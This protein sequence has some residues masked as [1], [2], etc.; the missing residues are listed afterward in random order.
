MRWRERG[1]QWRS[2][3][4]CPAR[5]QMGRETVINLKH[6]LIDRGCRA[7]RSDCL[8]EVTVAPERRREQ[9]IGRR[10]N[11]SVCTS[12]RCHTSRAHFGRACII[13]LV[14]RAGGAIVR[15]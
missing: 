14:Q 1:D 2:A 10:T 6:A 9:E 3:G 8:R 11:N 12:F 4:C 5:Q 15:D 7:A 13:R